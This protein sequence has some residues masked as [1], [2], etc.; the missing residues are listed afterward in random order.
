MRAIVKNPGHLGLIA[1]FDQQRH[2]MGFPRLHTHLKEIEH[3]AALA[4]T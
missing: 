4:T 2:P 3:G 1:R